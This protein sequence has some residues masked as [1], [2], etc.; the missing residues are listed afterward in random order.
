MDLGLEK[1]EPE[2]FICTAGAL[3]QETKLLSV[4]LCKTLVHEGCLMKWMVMYSDTTCRVCKHAYPFKFI[5]PIRVVELPPQPPMPLTP[6]PNPHKSRTLNVWGT[7]CAIL[8]VCVFGLGCGLLGLMTRYQ[9]DN[10]HAPM[11]VTVTLACSFVAAV[12][13]A[14]TAIMLYWK[15]ADNTESNQS[16]QYDV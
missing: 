12:G 14:H 3:D 2:C 11:G 9:S 13:L 10:A 7:F 15:A 5:E 6:L 4:C 8:A 1:V 16:S